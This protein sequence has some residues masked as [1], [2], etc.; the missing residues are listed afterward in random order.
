MQARKR[1]ES[2]DFERLE[3]DGY[4]VLPE[5]VRPEEIDRFEHDVAAIGEVLARRSG[6]EAAPG[7]RFSEVLRRSGPHRTMLFDHLKRL[8]VIERLGV[9]IGAAL[10]EAGLFRR[11]S[12]RAP[13]LWPTL[14]A[15]LPGEDTYMF[16]LHQDY[17]TTR[18]RHAWR[19]WIPLRSADEHYGTLR[20]AVGSHLLGPFRYVGEDTTYPHIDETEAARLGLE[21]RSFPVAAGD[22][23]LFDPRAIHGSVPNRSPRTKFVMLLHLQDMTTIV[24]PEDPNDPLRQFLDLTAAGK[25]AEKAGC[26]ILAAVASVRPPSPPQ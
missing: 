2:L 3:Q 25:A 14:R 7:E 11:H 10:E 8:Y 6:V 23:I 21:M 18:C 22:A 24:D 12:L 5:L 15:D 19:L 13:I 9:E 1:I 16:P 4:V 17:G 26:G 20:L